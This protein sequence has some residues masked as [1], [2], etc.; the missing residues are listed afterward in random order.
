MIDQMA[1]SEALLSSLVE[2]LFVGEAGT[3][4]CTLQT[5]MLQ[6]LYRCW[7]SLRCLHASHLEARVNSVISQVLLEKGFHKPAQR[8]DVGV[9]SSPIVFGVEGNVDVRYMTQ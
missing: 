9:S 6:S 1:Y 4:Q 2:V 3:M 5:V 8:N 7:P